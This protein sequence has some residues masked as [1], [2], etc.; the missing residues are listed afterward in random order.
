MKLGVSMTVVVICDKHVL[1]GEAFAEALREHGVVPI[2]TATP[3]EAWEAFAHNG[4]HRLLLSMRFPDSSALEMIRHVSDVWPRAHI[5]CRGAEEDAEIRSCIEAGADLVL[6]KHQP[7]HELV[8]VVAHGPTGPF[9]LRRGRR[10]RE[11][12]K[13]S[14][15]PAGTREPLAARFL[16]SRE[17]DVLR[18]L[19]SA[20]TTRSIAETLGISVT[21]ARG[22]IQSAFIK[23]GVH[24][25]VEAVTYAVRHSLV[26]FAPAD[27]TASHAATQTGGAALTP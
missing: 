5:I 17:R 14:A 4:V 3:A 6:S 16:T 23:L 21:T 10:H 27:V 26:E 2:V 20:E 7:L 12:V 24:S 1:F 19:A 13:G 25:R 18:L 22:Y 9:R 8:D 11:L 15:I